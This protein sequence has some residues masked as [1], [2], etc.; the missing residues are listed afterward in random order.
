MFRSFRVPERLFA[1]AMWVVSM[2]FAGFLIGLGGKIVG[3]L[4]GVDT[5]ITIRDF[6]DPAKAAPLRARRDSLI[7]ESKRTQDARDRAAQEHA[8]ARNVYSAQREQFD[9][10]IA[11]RTATTDPQ[12]DPEVIGRTRLLDSL[13]VLERG[14]SVTLT[15]DGRALRSQMDA[16]AGARLTTRIADGE[17]RS[18]VE[19]AQHAPLA[20]PTAPG[21]PPAATPSKPRKQVKATPKPAADE[22]GLFGG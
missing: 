6:I 14:Y 3:E 21:A 9:A 18:I 17:V 19:G 11:T 15:E 5:T 7:G 10:W 22:P 8:T 12:Q 4:P 1:I 2:V 20:L 16:K 13:K